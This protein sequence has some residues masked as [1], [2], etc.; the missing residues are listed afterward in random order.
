MPKCEPRSLARDKLKKVALQL[1]TVL[2]L[3]SLGVATI[4]IV[5][6]QTRAP[7]ELADAR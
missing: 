4:W 1:R 2:L 7:F 5:E 3:A 6:P